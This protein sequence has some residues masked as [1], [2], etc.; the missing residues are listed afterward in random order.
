MCHTRTTTD[1]TATAHATIIIMRVG[2][3]P[4]CWSPLCIVLYYNAIVYP[5]SVGRTIR[6]GAAA[7]WGTLSFR[8]PSRTR[9]LI[10]YRKTAAA[11]APQIPRSRG[12][13]RGVSVGKWEMGCKLG[14]RGWS[15]NNNVFYTM[16]KHGAL[17]GPD[18]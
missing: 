13:R 2:A 3:L 16:Y 7:P 15:N 9:V 14:E 8:S 18:R 11:A 1:S 10:N 4:A 6:A 17:Y 12:G 5:S